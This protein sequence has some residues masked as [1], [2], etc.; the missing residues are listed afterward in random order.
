MNIAVN[1]RDAAL[2]GQKAVDLS[3]SAQELAAF[4][5]QDP[6]MANECGVEVNALE[7]R[8]I[9]GSGICHRLAG[10]C[11]DAVKAGRTIQVDAADLEQLSR[12]EG[13]LSLGSARISLKIAAFDAAQGQE[14]MAKLGSIIGLATGAIGLVK[15]IW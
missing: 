8:T 11:I 3:L 14:G 9:L 5:V 15:S 7:A 1:P 6:G 13:V 4:A 12:L 2:L 10:K